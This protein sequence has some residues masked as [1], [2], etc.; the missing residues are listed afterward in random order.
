[1]SQVSGRA[2]RKHKQGKVLIQTVDP[3]NYILHDVIKND[4]RHTYQM[5]LAE[6]QNFGYPPYTRLIKLTLKHK[7]QHVL[8]RASEHFAQS[9]KKIFGSR[10]YG[11]EYPL[12]SRISNWYQKQ[13]LLKIE[14]QASVIKAKGLILK[15]IEALTNHAEYR[16]V[17]ILPDVDPM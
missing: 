1:M 8:D 10:V 13:I 15:E 7:D 16:G 2:G 4:F 17:I 12:I 9:L 14:R 6:R 5:Q 11:P 3:D